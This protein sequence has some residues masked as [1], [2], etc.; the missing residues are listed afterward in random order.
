MTSA[1]KEKVKEYSGKAEGKAEAAMART[2]EEREAADERAKAR[3]KAAK[4]EYYEEKAEH[5]EESAAHR[6]VTGRVPL[7]SHHHH[8]PVGADPT[9]PGSGAG[10]PAGEKYL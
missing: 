8:R 5:Q 6:G 4:A 1:T 10:H 7:T 3:E 9:Y 2:P